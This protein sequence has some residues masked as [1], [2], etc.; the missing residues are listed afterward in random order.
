MWE[1]LLVRVQD[2]AAGPAEC[3]GQQ[4][5]WRAACVLRPSRTLTADGSIESCARSYPPGAP[6]GTPCCRHPASRSQLAP[7]TGDRELHLGKRPLNVRQTEGRLKCCPAHQTVVILL[8]H[9][10]KLNIHDLLLCVRSQRDSPH[11]P[12]KENHMGHITRLPRCIKVKTSTTAKIKLA[13][14]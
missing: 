9:K 4:R 11:I 7:V 1:P 12:G 8:E 2:A 14:K 13:S 3:V 10:L 6:R 5:S